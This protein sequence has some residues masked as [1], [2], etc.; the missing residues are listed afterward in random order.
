MLLDAYGHLEANFPNIKWTKQTELY[1]RKTKILLRLNPCGKS[2][3]G[4]GEL[5]DTIYIFNE[6]PALLNQ[7]TEMNI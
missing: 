6:K 3:N 5:N 4:Y 1:V 2:S 7:K